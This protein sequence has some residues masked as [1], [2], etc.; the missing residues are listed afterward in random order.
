MRYL[1]AFLTAIMISPVFADTIANIEYDLPTARQDWKKV[2]SLKEDEENKT[3][4]IESTT[5]IYGPKED[6]LDN[7][8]EFFA[9][10]ANNFP[11]AGISVD[12]L[13]S[14]LEEAFDGE[15]RVVILESDADSALYEWSTV[16]EDMYIFS[17]TRGFFSEAGTT[18]L[19]YQTT[20]QSKAETERS[21]WLETLQTA[22]KV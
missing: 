15:V 18:L 1:L 4:G 22:K 5:F 6:S 17:V 12:D 11:S 3:D 2:R 16:E 8:I 14:G 19:M 20:D 13:K 10:H 21:L 7:P 9:V